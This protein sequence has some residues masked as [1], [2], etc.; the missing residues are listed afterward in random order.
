MKQLAFAALASVWG[1]V[2]PPGEALAATA[3]GTL[4][5][6]VACATYMA[7]SGQGFAVSYCATVIVP[8]SSPC[9]ALQ[10]I[11]NPTTQSSGGTVTFTI[12]TVNCSCTNS[13]FQ[14]NVTDRLPD[15]MTYSGNYTSWNGGSG[16]TWTRFASPDNGA[17]AWALNGPTIGQGAAYYLRYVLDQ[18]GPCKS[19][20]V[21]F[22]ANV[23]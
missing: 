4:I 16:G 1:L 22:T 5:T 17:T 13:A 18:I 3:D 20:L 8:I 11:A 10:K 7:A 9:I 6:N 21:Q 2:L 23:L 19:A 14:I 15:N 12:W